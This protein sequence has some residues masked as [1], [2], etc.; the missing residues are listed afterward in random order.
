MAPSTRAPT[1]ANW[2][3][4]RSMLCQPIGFESHHQAG[5]RTSTC[6]SQSQRTLDPTG[7]QEQIEPVS[8]PW[9]GRCHL[10][11]VRRCERVERAPRHHPNA[12]QVGRMSRQIPQMRCRQGLTKAGGAR[13]SS[14]PLAT[15]IAHRDRPAT[16]VL[17]QPAPTASSTRFRAASVRL[18]RAAN[19]KLAGRRR[20]T[21]GLPVVRPAGDKPARG[22]TA[23]SV[24]H[25]SATTAAK[26]TPDGLDST[27]GGNSGATSVREGLRPPDQQ[28]RRRPNLRCRSGFIRHA[29]REDRRLVPSPSATLRHSCDGKIRRDGKIRSPREFAAGQSLQGPEREALGMIRGFDNDPRR[30]F[31]STGDTPVAAPGEPPAA[32]RRPRPR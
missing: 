21:P 9:P 10:R 29:D 16:P 15:A 6:Q 20:P 24:Q 19:S 26:S 22:S 5:G 30:I 25:G 11:R 1:S 23:G 32:A 7:G 27:I 2:F 3:A 31:A 28:T 17:R 14:H 18:R 8:Q 4:A 12:A 13:A